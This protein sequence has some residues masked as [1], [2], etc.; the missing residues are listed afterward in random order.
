MADTL[1]HVQRINLDFSQ[2]PEEF[3]A[4]EV[5]LFAFCRAALLSERLNRSFRLRGG[6][7]LTSLPPRHPIRPQNCLYYNG[8]SVALP[9]AEAF[10][11]FLQTPA[12]WWITDRCSSGCTKKTTL[13]SRLLKILHKHE[14]SAALS[15]DNTPRSSSDRWVL[16]SS[17]S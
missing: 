9:H 3:R 1:W 2:P 11:R 16:V 12:A 4:S 10:T 13:S 6:R 14:L 7:K 5:H 17:F 8:L 15:Y